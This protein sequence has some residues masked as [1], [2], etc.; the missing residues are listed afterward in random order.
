MW[1]LLQWNP[2]A[3]AL[4]NPLLFFS[5]MIIDLHHVLCLKYILLTWHPFIKP[6]NGLGPCRRQITSPFISWLEKLKKSLDFS[7]RFCWS[8]L[9]KFQVCCTA[10]VE[11]KD[12]GWLVGSSASF[13]VSNC[14]LMKAELGP[15]AQKP[16]TSFQIA[17]FRFS[18][19]PACFS[20]L[21]AFLYCLL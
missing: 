2:A 17:S 14:D 18:C 15:R 5:K 6:E 20:S 16:L 11:R 3:A 13:S 4:V 10:G 1:A 21:R 7:P 8:L 19:F 9:F 12:W